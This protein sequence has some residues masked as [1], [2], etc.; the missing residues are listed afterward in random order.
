MTDIETVRTLTG[1]SDISDAFISFYL[2]ASEDFIKS[3]CN[4]DTIPDGLKTTLLEMT[5][6]RVKANSSGGKPALGQGVKSVAS[7]SDGNQSIGYAIGGSGTKSFISEEDFV[8]AYGDILGR[9]RRMVVGN[10]E[11]LK[12]CGSRCLHTDSFC[13]SHPHAPYQ[14]PNQSGR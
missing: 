1:D 13:S 3:Y 14:H 10:K 2:Q 11:N 12:T 4:I 7:M 5:A 8:A 6:M 9:Y